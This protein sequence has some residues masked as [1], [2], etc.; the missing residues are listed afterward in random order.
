MKKIWFLLILSLFL[1]GCSIWAEK[2]APVLTARISASNNIN[3]NLDGT[4]SPVV[5]QIYQLKESE[6]FEQASFLQIYSDE[7]SALKS[8]LISSKHLPSIFPATKIN[9][10]FELSPDAK[11]IGV[12][13]GFADYR[14]ANNKALFEITE[15]KNT[16]INIYLNGVNL[17][18]TQGDPKD[19]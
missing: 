4:P 11:F 15:F 3:P 1:Q 17:T 10:S 5:V 13:A 14:E 9:E 19:G 6:A 8:G 18:L 2:G 16:W 7:Q 12:I